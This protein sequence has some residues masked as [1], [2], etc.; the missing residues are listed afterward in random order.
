MYIE[1]ETRASGCILNKPR[2]M[3]SDDINYDNTNGM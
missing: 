3:Y 2:I 1:I